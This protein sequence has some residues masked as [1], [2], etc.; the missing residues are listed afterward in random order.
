MG[1]KSTQNITREEAIYRIEEVLERL[2]KNDFVALNNDSCED[3]EIVE[4]SDVNYLLGDI[5]RTPFIRYSMFEN[6][7]VVDKKE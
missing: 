4:D 2:K 3:G 5:M 7:C 1:I 6:Y